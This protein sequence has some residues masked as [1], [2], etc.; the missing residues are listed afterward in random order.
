MIYSSYIY[1]R[2]FCTFVLVIVFCNIPMLRISHGTPFVQCRTSFRSH[3]CST[4]LD[5]ETCLHSGC[6]CHPMSTPLKLRGQ[7]FF[8]TWIQAW[9]S[10]PRFALYI[11]ISVYSHPSC[12]EVAHVCPEQVCPEDPSGRIETC[13]LLLW[14]AK[15]FG[16]DPHLRWRFLSSLKCAHLKP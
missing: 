5:W 12:V 2:A 9:Y 8:W 4:F 3:K 6:L 10:V 13:L 15:K 7:K 14:E 11:S 16:N 1:F